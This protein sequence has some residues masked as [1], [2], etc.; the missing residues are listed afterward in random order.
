[1]EPA[2][3]P[4]L[5]VLPARPLAP[6]VIT[7]RSGTVC[8]PAP[9][10]EAFSA[11]FCGRGLAGGRAR[12]PSKVRARRPVRPALYLAGVRRPGCARSAAG[13]ALSATRRMGAP[14]AKRSPSSS[15]SA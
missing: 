10:R 15:I 13:R 1:M 11:R 3:P 2:L 12:A 14:G 8:V 5:R 4:R 6:I 9:K 7:G